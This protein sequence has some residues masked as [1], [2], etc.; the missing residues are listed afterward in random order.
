MLDACDIASGTSQDLNGNGIPDECFE[1]GDCNGNLVSDIVDIQ[2]GSS[3]DC[4]GN[5][6]PDECDP[7]CDFDGV[8]DA[9]DPPG[10]DCNANGVD[11]ACEELS[12]ATSLA[13]G[14]PLPDGRVATDGSWVAVLSTEIDVGYF[15]YLFQRDPSQ[16][17][18]LFQALPIPEQ[19][20]DLA[21]TDGVVFVG[22]R[23]SDEFANAGGVVWVYTLDSSGQWSRTQTLGGVAPEDL[24]FFGAALDADG[25]RLVV[26]ATGEDR[27]GRHP[28]V[29]YVFARDGSG[30]WVVQSE[31][32]LPRLPN[33]LSALGDDVAVS[34]DRILSTTRGSSLFT[35]AFV[36]FFEPMSGGWM[37]THRETVSTGVFGNLVVV[38]D[39]DG[40]VAGWGSPV[41]G[42]V[43]LFVPAAG[44]S[45]WTPVAILRETFGAASPFGAGL[46]LDGVLGE[47]RAAISSLDRSYVFVEGSDGAWDLLAT[48][49]EDGLS[50]PAMHGFDVVNTVGG[51]ATAHVVDCNANGVADACEIATGAELDTN[52]NGIPDSCE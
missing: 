7:D 17:W 16:G 5:L 38:V 10:S 46:R 51:L 44:A 6:V 35:P 14:S 48:L 20:S 49:P 52:G 41:L 50:G 2:S 32:T 4:D 28:G 47:R 24:D 33:A 25:D 9:C 23:F 11:D 8:P 30:A 34:G 31:V 45:S 15:L 19:P 36:H 43:R 21:M 12:P 13:R 22:S 27:P 29:V 1:D 3:S 40:D 18:T 26:T 39:V 42:E 37:E